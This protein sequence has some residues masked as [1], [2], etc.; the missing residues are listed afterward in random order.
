MDRPYVDFT[1]RVT[2]AVS[3]G[4]RAPRSR[5]GLTHDLAPGTVLLDPDDIVSGTAEAFNISVSDLRKEGRYRSLGHVAEARY[6]GFWLLRRHTR[7]SS[8]QAARVMGGRDHSAAI[9]G[10]SRCEERRAADA[11]FREVT[12]KLER[13]LEE[14]A[15]GA[16]A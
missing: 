10:V 6:A 1:N 2:A 7:L 3:A 15:K 8:A 5:S 11:W 16:A 4:L 13:K 12:E 14:K 9:K